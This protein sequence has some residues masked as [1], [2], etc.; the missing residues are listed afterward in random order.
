MT[1]RKPVE[2]SSKAPHFAARQGSMRQIY[3][4]AAHLLPVKVKTPSLATKIARLVL[5]AAQSTLS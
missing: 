5:I 2:L 1:A 3:E 4:E